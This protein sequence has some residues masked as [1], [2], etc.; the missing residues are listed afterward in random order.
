MASL[1]SSSPPPSPRWFARFEL[2]RELGRGGMGVVYEAT[3]VDLSRRVALKLLPRA[4][5]LDPMRL[6][7]FAQEVR[8]A[9]QVRHPGLVEVFDGGVY[10]GQPYLA[11]ELVA[12][13]T[14]ADALRDDGPL[15][16]QEAARIV[17]E[18]AR[19]VHALHER[20]IVHRDL[21]PANVLL[22]GQ[23]R[24]RV[25][26]FGLALMLGAGDPLG[27]RVAGTPGCMA[28]EQIDGAFGEVGPASDVFALGA[29]LFTALTGQTP[30]AAG[31]PLELMLAVTDRPA[32][33]LRS[34]QPGAPIELEAICARC[35]VREQR[36][37]FASAADLAEQLE[38]FQRGED[39]SL[40]LPGLLPRLQNWRRGHLALAVHLLAIATL[41]LIAGVDHLLL[42]VTDARFFW[43]TSVTTVSLLSASFACDHALRRR[44]QARAPLFAWVSADALALFV[45]ASMGDGPMS[46]VTRVFPLLIA[47]SSL[48][49]R[50]DVIVLATLASTAAY[51]GLVAHAELG[52]DAFRL[53]VATYLVTGTSFVLLGWI[54]T[55]L[56]RRLRRVLAFAARRAGV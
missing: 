11:M 52:R 44:P 4:H 53:P 21:K 45:V 9:A 20:G 51:A 25:T 36:H 40:R 50:Q 8:A 38:R 26:D 56:V 1:V 35:L 34:V 7:A 39:V 41:W 23:G 48:W 19:A 54:G 55:R 15:P 6:A 18:V 3:Q 30:H 2:H 12:G 43:W 5:G 10:E 24:A 16:S 22:D 29:L 14:L 37:R 46:A 33:T 13:R 27:D 17:A 31:N 49:Q 47:A 28:P 42:A 32:R